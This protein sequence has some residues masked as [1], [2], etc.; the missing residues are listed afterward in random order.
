MLHPRPS[1]ALRVLVAGLLGLAGRAQEGRKVAPPMPFVDLDAKVA[2]PLPA[3][4]QTRPKPVHP[5]GELRA[6]PRAAAKADPAGAADIVLRHGQTFR[7]GLP[8]GQVVFDAG[9]GVILAEGDTYKASFAAGR[10]TYV[11]RFG[12]D[13]PRNYPLALALESAQLGGTAAPLRAAPPALSGT[14][15]RLDHG[16]LVERYDLHPDRIEQEFEI[17]APFAGELSVTL[18]ADTDL[19]AERGAGGLRF[20]NELGHVG[21]TDAVLVD[22]LGRRLPMTTDHAAGRITLRAA[23]ATLAAATF[24]I[25]VDPVIT[26]IAVTSS[27]DRL[28]R[29]DLA[30]SS[31]AGN[32]LVVWVRVFSSTD[33][34]VHAV[35]VDAAG[36]VV[37][38]SGSLID[39][40]TDWWNECRVACCGHNFLVVASRQPAGGGPFAIWGR[41]R[42]TSAPSMGPQ[43]Q[44]SGTEGGDKI[45]PDVGG[46]FEGPTNFC[47]VW[48]RRWTPTDHDIHYR[49]VDALGS[50]S[51][52][53]QAIDNSSSN[54]DYRPRIA[55][56]S[57][58]GPAGRQ[59]WPVVW[60]RLINGAQH[61]IW[62][63]RVQW[64]GTLATPPFLID[65]ASVDDDNSAAVT[66]LTSDL[67]G[68]RYFLVAFTT[69][70][71]GNPDIYLRA[72]VDGANPVEVSDDFLGDLEGLTN[73][74][75]LRNQGRAQLDSDGCRFAVAYVERVDSADRDAYVSTVDLTPDLRAIDP[76][77][78]LTDSTR[79][80]DDVG[81]VAIRSGGGGAHDYGTAW[82]LAASGIFANFLQGAIYRGITP[83]GGLSVRT[84][85]CGSTSLSFPVGLVPAVGGTLRFD[86]SG[87]RP[88]IF[89]VG[90]PTTLPLCP[91]ATCTLGATPL[92]LI[93]GA[94]LVLS[95]PCNGNLVGGT[96]AVQGIAVASP[97]GC[98]NLAQIDTSITVDVTFR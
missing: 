11:P 19:R 25:T 57:G 28:L 49:M 80:T 24:P 73:E 94:S 79:D 71:R 70:N 63:A 15:V 36:N 29:T 3:A 44:I 54:N 81:L 12:S 18:R 84:T 5:G 58:A 26:T 37:P 89:V 75:R 43:F 96:I 40:T 86:L 6:V 7:P 62:G 35:A 8:R 31:P 42:S 17:A 66:S 92:V 72:F 10:F 67:G 87:P 41:T 1:L 56:S 69:N 27:P 78:T 48:D 61:D 95:I 98:P 34:D 47:V 9:G 85:Q 68:A 52:G 39:N 50:L 65:G 22:A 21:Y 97:F 90:L 59:V 30:F 55:K 32:Y 64:S 46:E 4:P 38:N 51:G 13:A 93:P 82:N 53:V 14:T 2:A 91:P 76:R 88:G 33:L 74:Q 83:S 77:V 45:T 16:G 60:D 23:A 20:G